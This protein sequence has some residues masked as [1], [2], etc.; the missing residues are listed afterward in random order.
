MTATIALVPS[1]ELWSEDPD[2][3]YRPYL[4]AQRGEA[5]VFGATA[6][7]RDPGMVMRELAR[8]AID[9]AAKCHGT[10]LLTSWVSSIVSVRH[11]LSEAARDRG[12][13]VPVAGID[14]A[15]R[16]VAGLCYRGCGQALADA[17]RGHTVLLIDEL[18]AACAGES[19]ARGMAVARRIANVANVAVLI[20]MEG[21]R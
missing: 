20:G 17:A 11:A 7:W 14:V 15:I 12:V 10:V 9:V 21:K 1:A 18:V 4:P 19:P 13:P 6:P 8:M 3:R 5:Y 16:P 2:N